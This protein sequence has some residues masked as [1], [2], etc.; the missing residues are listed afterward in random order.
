MGRLIDE[1]LGAIGHEWSAEDLAILAPSLPHRECVWVPI[2]G[3]CSVDGISL[4]GGCE[5]WRA[6]RANETYA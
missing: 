2:A 6:F 1:L 3:N 4:T 5:G